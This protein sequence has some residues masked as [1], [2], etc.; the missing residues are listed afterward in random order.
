MSSVIEYTHHPIVFIKH[1]PVHD[2]VSGTKIIGKTFND[3]EPETVVVFN[4]W[5]NEHKCQ[6]V[7]VIPRGASYLVNLGSEKDT[8]T[9]IKSPGI[10]QLYENSLCCLSVY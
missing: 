10:S 9:Q 1:S 6:I 5:E 2:N 4:F 8:G 3:L 7:N